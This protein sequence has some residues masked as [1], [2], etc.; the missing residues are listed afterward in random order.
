VRRLLSTV[1]RRSRRR[2]LINGYLR[3]H[4]VRKLQLGAAENVQPG[5]LNTDLHGYGHGGELVYLDARR[6]FPLPDASFDFVFSEHMLE[7]L[8]YEDGQQCLRECLRVLRPGGTIRTA[9]PSLER[10]ARLYDGGEVSER[11]VRWAVDTLEP[12]VR[13]YMPGVAVNNFFRSWGHRFI[14]DKDTLRH[15]LTEAGFVDIQS[16]RVGESPHPELMGLERHLAEAPEINEYET[17]VLEA[18]RP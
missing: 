7:H 8:T 11:Y 5:W 3:E 14:Y 1:L 13:A 2:W 15:A 17:F 10:L 4:A 6:P 9:T 16:L 18:R 12:E